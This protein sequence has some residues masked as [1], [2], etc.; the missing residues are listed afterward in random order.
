MIQM[1]GNGHDSMI[2]DGK[3]YTAMNGIF[4]IS[5]EHVDIAVRSGFSFIYPADA[6]NYNDR[7]EEKIIEKP[8][9]GGG[10]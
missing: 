7:K 9:K 2:V 1:H 10:K 8:K 4:D 6:A 5:P 3:T